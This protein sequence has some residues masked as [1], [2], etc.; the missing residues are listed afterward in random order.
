MFVALGVAEGFSVVCL[1][2]LTSLHL[3]DIGLK[4][5]AVEMNWKGFCSGKGCSGKEVDLSGT[6]FCKLHQEPEQTP[7]V[8]LGHTWAGG[9]SSWPCGD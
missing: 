8:T 5:A 6:S 3:V 9:K 2:F 1:K 7:A 4:F